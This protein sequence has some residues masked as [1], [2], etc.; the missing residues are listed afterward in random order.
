[1]MLS[2]SVSHVTNSPSMQGTDFVALS[3]KRSIA[4]KVT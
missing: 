4:F 1:M 3:L 2:L